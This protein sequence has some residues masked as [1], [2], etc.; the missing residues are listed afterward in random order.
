MFV[1][2]RVKTFVLLNTHIQVEKNLNPEAFDK[3]PVLIENWFIFSLTWSVGATCDNDGRLKFNEWLRARM[4]EEKS[5]LEF[6]EDGLVYDYFLDD[7]VI[8]AKE[9]DDD[10]LD[11]SEAPKA[12]NVNSSSSHNAII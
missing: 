12:K 7:S 11:D 3:L 9:S 8:F 6:P 1:N 10:R 2:L 5:H 4:A